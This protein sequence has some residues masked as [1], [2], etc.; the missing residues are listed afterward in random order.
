MSLSHSRLLL[1]PGIFCYT[2][3][4]LSLWNTL[5][6]IGGSEWEKDRVPLAKILPYSQQDTVLGCRWLKCFIKI[7]CSIKTRS[8]FD[9]VLGTEDWG[10]KGHDSKCSFIGDCCGPLC[11]WIF[12]IVMQWASVLRWSSSAS[13]ELQ[14]G[15]HGGWGVSSWWSPPRCDVHTDTKWF[16]FSLQ[17]TA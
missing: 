13:G 6:Y 8:K 14:R 9:K 2:Q 12:I 3:S 7:I 16:W 1:F 11:V 17:K 15:P 10:K 5:K 4:Y